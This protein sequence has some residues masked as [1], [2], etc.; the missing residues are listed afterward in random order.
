MIYVDITLIYFHHD[1]VPNWIHIRNESYD[2]YITT[3]WN[4]L[5]YR[6]N[7][8]VPFS[9]TSLERGI[10]DANSDKHYKKNDTSIVLKRRGLDGG[11]GA[12]T[13][14]TDRGLVTNKYPINGK[15][16]P[17]RMI[18]LEDIPYFSNIIDLSYVCGKFINNS[19]IIWCE[20]IFGGFSINDID[21]LWL[22][23]QAS[24][25][26]IL[27][28]T[29]GNKNIIYNKIIEN[30]DYSEIKYLNN[31]MN[32]WIQMRLIRPIKRIFSYYCVIETN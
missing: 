6:F 27:E 20:K 29:C 26:I 24:H 15:I 14:M 18:I 2:Q 10:R 22:S 1:D 4:Y 9:K 25:P 12:C 23:E 11:I 7:D 19:E 31:F 13:I 30:N 16:L 17:L 8:K 32:C 5:L 28:E 3:I 21:K